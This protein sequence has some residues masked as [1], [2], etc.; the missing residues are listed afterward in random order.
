M[1]E[2]DTPMSPGLPA[3][4]QDPGFLK[5]KECRRGHSAGPVTEYPD[6]ATL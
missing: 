2:A 1:Q 3:Y 4:K 6:H 5:G